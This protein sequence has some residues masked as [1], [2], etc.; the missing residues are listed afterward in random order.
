MNI[1]SKKILS[2]EDLGILAAEIAG[3]ELTTSGELRVVIRHHR[4]FTEWRRA[5]HEIALSEFRRLGMHHTRDH[6]GVLIFLLVSERRFHI[7]ADEGIHA[8]VADGTWDAVA[9][10]MSA[11]FRQGNFRQ[12][13]SEAIAAVGT[14]LAREFPRTE[15]KG[16]ELPDDVIEE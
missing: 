1:F 12:G 5:I 10:G 8:K 16:N 15:G 7:I 11:H 6:T 4:H 2:K 13:I 14:V 9:A 3:M